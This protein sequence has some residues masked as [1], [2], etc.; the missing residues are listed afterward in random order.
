MN[1]RSLPL[2][3]VL[4]GVVASGCSGAAD[5]LPQSSGSQPAT[6][7]ASPPIA[8]GAPTPR[9]VDAGSAA[10]DAGTDGGLTEAGA[11]C[12]NQATTQVRFV[13]VLDA[14]DAPPAQPWDPQSPATTSD[15]TTGY[16][17]LDGN[18]KSHTGGISYVHETDGAWTAH[19]LTGDDVLGTADG[20]V[21]AEN[22]TMRL[23]FTLDGRL[24]N[25]EV[26]MAA[27]VLVPAAPPQWILYDFGDPLYLGGTGT[28]GMRSYGAGDQITSA[29]QDGH[30]CP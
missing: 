4:A 13:G 12:V 11:R 6:A 5:S 27:P 1:P 3:L 2:A 16:T 15:F 20:G 26:L 29:R 10:P 28:K 19:A 23:S 25:V 8:S 30:A 7:D 22:A 9:V 21:N 18:G 24:R 17:F 14:N